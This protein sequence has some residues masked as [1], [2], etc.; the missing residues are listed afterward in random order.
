M[1]P[2]DRPYATRA[3]HYAKHRPRYPAELLQ[4]LTKECGLS[5]DWVIADVGSGTGLLTELFLENGNAAFGVE[6]D[7]AMRE[8]GE[9]YLR[10]YSEFRSV[11]GTAEDTTLAENCTDIVTVGQTFH[12]FDLV[13]A[14]AEFRRILRPGGWVAVVWYQPAHDGS[15]FLRAQSEVM[16]RHV[17]P[18]TQP[19][20]N[21]LDDATLSWFLGEERSDTRAVESFEMLGL[22]GVKGAAL[23][24]AYAPEPGGAASEAMMTELTE[25]FEQHQR[26][27]QVHIPI[28]FR[29]CVGRI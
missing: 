14:K 17:R 16:Q 6:P 22:D 1:S 3:E 7:Q 11:A 25:L 24:S 9:H 19:P 5:P 8:A 12:W 10:A 29:L 23:S 21:R 28:T 20:R 27:G 18:L 2:T 4:I 15:P 26:D 13:Q